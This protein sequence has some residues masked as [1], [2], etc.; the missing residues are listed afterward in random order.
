MT[1]QTKDFT[2]LFGLTGFS[3]QLLESHLTLYQGYVSNVNKLIETLKTL[4]RE[5]KTNQVEFAELKRRFAWEFNG[6]RLHEYYFEN[7]SKEPSQ[8][9]RQSELGKAITEEWGSFENW[10]KIFKAIGLMRGIGWVVLYY[11]KISKRLFNTWINEHDLGHLSGAIPLLVMDVFEHAY[12]LDYGLKKGD[13]L[14]AFFQA[15]NWPKIV[16]RF[17]QV[18]S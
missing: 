17:K 8:L 16:E 7:L 14:E 1:Y 4:E 15:I 11:D 2:Y 6:M 3:Q 12:I 9:E 13:Y 18:N 5:E 10:V